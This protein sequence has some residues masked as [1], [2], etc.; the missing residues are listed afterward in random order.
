MCPC[1]DCLQKA[2][3]LCRGGRKPCK[4]YIGPLRGETRN[5]LLDSPNKHPRKWH[6]RPET[7][8]EADRLETQRA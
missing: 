3:C 7:K 2:H 1:W 5:W 4:Y 8:A 6:V